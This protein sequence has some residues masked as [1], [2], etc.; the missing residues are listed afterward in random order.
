[1]PHVNIVTLMT[2]AEQAEQDGD[3]R[4]SHDAFNAA[5]WL[6][7]QRLFERHQVANFGGKNIA[8]GQRVRIKKGTVIRSMH[9]RHSRDNPKVAG[10]DYVVT[11]YDVYD[12]WMGSS[13]HPHE[14]THAVR[15]AQIV[16]PGEGGYWCYVDTALVE[17]V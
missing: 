13:W 15:N 5:R 12:G 6:E 9:P 7:E 11:V 4:L 2:L 3:S 1:M 16:W 10:R 8:K 14:I 17:I